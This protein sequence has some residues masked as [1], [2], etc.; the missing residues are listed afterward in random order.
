M[1]GR[2]CET[3]VALRALAAPFVLA[4]VSLLV[5]SGNGLLGSGLTMLIIGCP[6][7][8]TPAHQLLHALFRRE[9]ELPR[10]AE[11][12]LQTR[13]LSRLFNWR[14]RL[15]EDRYLMTWSA[16]AVAW[17][18]V[19][20]HYLN[21]ILGLLLR[22]SFQTP[23]AEAPQFILQVNLFLVA[24]AI[25][26]VLALPL[27][28]ATRSLWRLLAPRMFSAESALTR[29]SAGTERPP[30]DDLGRF[31]SANLLFSQLPDRVL[32]QVLKAVK[33]VVA[34][35][36]AT[37]IRERDLGDSLFIIHAGRVE[38]SKEGETGQER[39]V[40]VLGKGDIFG[41]IALLDKVPRTSTVRAVE[42]TAMLV[43]GKDDFERLLVS[44]LGTEQV[45]ETIQICAFL[46]RHPLFADWH[47]QAL[48]AIAHH[49]QF[50]ACPAGQS[51]LQQG[52]SNDHFYLVYEGEFRVSQ[53]GR[54]VAL[55]GPGDFAGEISLLR[56]SAAVADVVAVRNSLCLRL[57]RAD[58]LR[59]VSHDFLTGLAVESV[60]EERLAR[61]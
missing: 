34:E 43:L 31:L 9:Y 24:V 4:L 17:L 22:V 49:F 13:L 37:I 39:P 46:R 25:A 8:A 40:A 10:C 35:P 1:G 5:E 57:A 52:E 55:L 38:V 30:D 14:E 48:L 28:L 44:A 19:T 60:L 42:R 15:A 61:A 27:W 36:G 18:G 21:E 11:K 47:P 12:F 41:E 3:A 33:Y 2:V 29:A 45:R 20:L 23:L 58:F 16:Y 50:S 51:I 7:G 32:Q 59:F 56:E 54:Q 6:F 53:G 26:V